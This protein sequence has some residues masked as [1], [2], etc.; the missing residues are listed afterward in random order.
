MRKS[1]ELSGMNFSSNCNGCSYKIII[2]IERFDIKPSS[3]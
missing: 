2:T 3:F 1:T